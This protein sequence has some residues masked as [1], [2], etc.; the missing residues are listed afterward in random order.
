MTSVEVNNVAVP[1]AGIERIE[2]ADS[3][4]IPGKHKLRS[5]PRVR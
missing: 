1:P 3:G 2:E 5:R 4:G